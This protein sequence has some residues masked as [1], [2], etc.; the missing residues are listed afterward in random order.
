MRQTSNPAEHPTGEEL[1]ARARDLIP[2]LAERAE[3]QSAARTVLPETMA[4]LREAGLWRVLQPA[5]WGGFEMYPGIFGEI[6]IAL[7]E[8]DVSVGWVYGVLAVHNFHLALFDDRLAQKVWGDDNSVL[9]SSSYLPVGKA[10]PVNGGFR[11]SGHWK[12]SSGSD[13]CQWAMLGGRIE[14]T[15][16]PVSG[17]FVV[18]RSEYT[19]RDT[20]HVMGL[21]GT[22]SQDIIVED[23]FVPDYHF[24]ASADYTH[25]KGPGLAVNTGTLFRAPM[26]QIFYRC[27]N[28]A[29]IGG[30]QGL[31]NEFLGYGST[32]VNAFGSS[33]T[34]DPDALVAIATAVS[35]VDE[36]KVIMHR[37]FDRI[38]ACAERNE[39]PSIEERLR[40][41]FQSAS[42]PHR[43]G[44]VALQL[45]KSSGGSGIFNTRSFGRHLNDIL[46]MGQHAANQSNIY[47]RN[48]AGTLFGH[49]STDPSY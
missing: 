3:R 37:N 35:T 44:A 29:A 32:R 1:I 30:L 8:G 26:M 6:Q 10:T 28:N 31:I 41:K 21:K 5:R 20:W 42:V 43:C 17:T 47:G 33:T 25:V 34:K 18:P 36:L 2:T 48:Y 13:H 14:G 19:I 27:V 15:D 7:A 9:I 16:P 45:F 12:F 39:V 46:A 40:F 24:L 23:V 22:G 4:D 49:L 38:M 11:L